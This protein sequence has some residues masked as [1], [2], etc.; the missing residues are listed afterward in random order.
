MR[1]VDY[2]FVFDG[3]QPD[4]VAVQ[5]TSY[6]LVHCLG[7]PYV[8]FHTATD[9]GAVTVRCDPCSSDQDRKAYAAM[10]RADLIKA[11]SKRLL[12]AP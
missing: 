8:E 6:D 9:Q 7:L 12:A 10:V 11:L 3:W 4:D 2:S 1:L 5:S